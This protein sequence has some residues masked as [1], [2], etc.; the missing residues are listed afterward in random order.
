MSQTNHFNIIILDDNDFYNK[1]LTLQVK[2]FT[3]EM[4]L[5]KGYSFDIRSYTHASDC[6]RNLQADIDIAIVDFYLGESNALSV[7]KVIK[8]KCEDCK[9]V[10]VS[11]ANNIRS[12]YE[13]LNE[14]AYHFIYKDNKTLSECCFIVEEIIS[15]KIAS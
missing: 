4:Q 9:V 2:R 3:E 10:I 11:K 6:L 14:E 8:E 15:R 7:I 1:I 12:Y 5:E 13:N